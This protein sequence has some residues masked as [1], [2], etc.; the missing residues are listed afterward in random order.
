MKFMLMSIF[1]S[2]VQF[3]PC[4]SSNI[5]QVGWCKC[6]NHYQSPKELG[7][8]CAKLCQVHLAVW[9]QG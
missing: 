6:F 9:L 5:Q 3:V 2:A 4:R 1:D 8:L 7:L